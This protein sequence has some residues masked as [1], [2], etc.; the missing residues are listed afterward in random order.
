MFRYILTLFLE[1]SNGKYNGKNDVRNTREIEF[2]DPYHFN[3]S[4]RKWMVDINF[5]VYACKNGFGYLLFPEIKNCFFGSMGWIWQ[6]DSQDCLYGVD[7][8]KGALEM[9]KIKTFEDVETA[10]LVDGAHGIHMIKRFVENYPDI[11]IQFATEEEQK[12]ILQEERTSDEEEIVSDIW[13]E[14][15]TG[16]FTDENGRK[17]VFYTGPYDDLMA[18]REDHFDQLPEKEK[19]AF[20]GYY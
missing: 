15:I 5:K 17:W 18:Y 14:I 8:F 9:K 1:V 19:E 20:N 10:L 2:K 7:Q 4:I 11:A 16:S 12:I 6:E 13:Y 3:L